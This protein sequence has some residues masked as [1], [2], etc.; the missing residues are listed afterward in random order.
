MRS[1]LETTSNR[2]YGRWVQSGHWVR[3]ILQR[4]FVD[5]PG[6]R[7][8]YSTGSSHLLSA[9]LTRATGV[10][11]LEYARRHLGVPLGIQVRA[12]TRDPQGIYMGGNEMSFTTR[13][14]A[15]IGSVMLNSGRHG[16]RQVVSEDWV[17]A[18]RVRRVR[19]ERQFD[20]SYGYGWWMRDMAGHEVIYAWGYGGQFIF[21]VP[22]LETVVVATSVAEPGEERREQ[23]D[24]IYDIVEEQI[25][26]AVSATVG[27][28][29]GGGPP[30]V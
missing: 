16:G 17:R 25:L 2:N 23:R 27:G 6:D 4:P 18:S 9:I 5:S 22:A 1:G 26:P 13:E 8:I 21:V 7:M 19:S 24:A 12:W 29:A 20:R 10:S 30:G 3:H 14:L 15:A 28:R 11:T